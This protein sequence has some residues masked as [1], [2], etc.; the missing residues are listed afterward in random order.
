MRL[1]TEV[2]EF[3]LYEVDYVRS[4]VRLVPAPKLMYR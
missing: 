1:A 4:D 3:N 2:L